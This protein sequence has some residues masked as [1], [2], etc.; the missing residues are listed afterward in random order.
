MQTKY[1]L[2]KSSLSLLLGFTLVFSFFFHV[3]PAAALGATSTDMPLSL[4]RS[5]DCSGEDV[6]LSGTIHLVNQLQA[7]GSVIGHFNYSDVKGVGLTS[8]TIYRANAVDNFRLSDPFP[9]SIT[10]ERN[11][12]LLSRGSSSNLLVQAIY[13]ITVTANGDV[14][15]SIDSLT[16]QCT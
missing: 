2:I 13:H 12:R 16:M 5:A 7:D 10:S 11:F 6:E 8:G 9:S 1:H 3:S 15:A 4:I 14:T